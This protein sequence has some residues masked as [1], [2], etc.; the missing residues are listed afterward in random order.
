VH[1]PTVARTEDRYSRLDATASGVQYQPTV[2]EQE[3]ARQ[4]GST[5]P[6]RP[7]ALVAAL[8]GRPIVLIGMMGA[9]KSS[10][11]KRLAV[12]LGIPFKDADNEIEEAANTTIEEIFENHGEAFF[13]SGERRVIQRLLGEAPVVVATGGGAFVDL[14]T[15]KAINDAGIAIWL[16]ADLEVLLARVRRRSNRPLLKGPD[17]EGTMRRLVEER[18][19]AYEEAPIHIHS[20]EVSHDVV[21]EEV[22]LSLDRYL[23]DHPAPAT[24]AN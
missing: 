22:L 17:P 8:A 2:S 23:A 3:N 4:A 6:P 11:G 9:G 19:P 20:R 10:I 7:S 13:R 21:I 16:K 5:P 1:S 14:D 18:Y 12:R 24:E 15:R